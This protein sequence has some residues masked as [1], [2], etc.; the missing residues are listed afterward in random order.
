M[1]PFG[2]LIITLFL[3]VIVS[4]VD[5]YA[6]GEASNSV[7]FSII[8]ALLNFVAL[9]S[10]LG[11]LVL[12]PCGIIILAKKDEDRPIIG[13]KVLAGRGERWL[14]K[15]LDGLIGFLPPLI[16]AFI[17]MAASGE[18]KDTPTSTGLFWLVFL[19]IGIV[20][21]YYL[22]TQGQTI[23]KKWLKIRI[24]DAETHELAGFA[25]SVLLRSILN[26]VFCLVPLYGLVDAL[27][28]FREDRRCVHDLLAGTIVV[29][30]SENY[31]VKGNT[32]T[33][34]SGGKF[35]THCGNKIT[36]RV[37]FCTHCGSS[38]A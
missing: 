31:K 8:K 27:F 29:Y 23:A 4:L 2:I 24:V 1:A 17:V 15:F 32:P 3:R 36:S 19:A 18:S 16:I 28:I 10:V 14:A 6:N 38:A 34:K 22:T 21:A 11:A 35:C 7:I 26:A 9:I 37:K 33:N 13:N 5:V 12:I 25:K 30:A 20:Q